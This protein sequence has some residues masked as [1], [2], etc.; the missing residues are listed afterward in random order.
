M[1]SV[2][3]RSDEDPLP[4]GETAKDVIGQVS[5]Q[6]G[7]PPSAAG[8]TESVPFAREG[9][10]DLVPALIAAE[11]GKAARQ[12]TAR[13]KFAELPLDEHWQ[14]VPVVACSRLR[15]EG[16]DKLGTFRTEDT[17]ERCLKFEGWMY[18]ASAA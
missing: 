10:Q 16:L 2:A 18:F 5:G 12:D 14:T 7:H 6:L 1:R 17:A 13:K 9:D 11:A 3:A 4:D 8:W 15:E